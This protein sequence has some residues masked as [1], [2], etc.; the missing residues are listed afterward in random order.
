MPPL[1]AGFLAAKYHTNSNGY[2]LNLFVRF[3]TGIRVRF[4]KA[5]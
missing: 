5:K 3:V 4:C 1:D 2:V